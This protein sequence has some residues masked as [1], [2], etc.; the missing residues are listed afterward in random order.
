MIPIGV[1]A[2]LTGGIVLLL[3]LGTRNA[4][5]DLEGDTVGAR[6]AQAGGVAAD[7]RCG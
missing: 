6:N 4:A 7:L 3:P 5:L 2:G 1:F